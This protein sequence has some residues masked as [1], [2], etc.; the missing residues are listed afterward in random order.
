MR[1]SFGP[2]CGACGEGVD[3]VGGR[4]VDGVGVDCDEAA[5]E[6]R[7]ALE[8]GELRERGKSSEERAC[9]VVDDGSC[10]GRVGVATERAECI[11]EDAVVV[12][13]AYCEAIDSSGKSTVFV[14][15]GGGAG[16][17][18]SGGDGDLCAVGGEKDW[19]ASSVD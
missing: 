14:D 5:C 9:G 18:L 11:Y 13:P 7:R 19:S 16:R 3:G 8:W 12:D 1:E 2:D 17:I 6:L 15:A 10:V 4:G